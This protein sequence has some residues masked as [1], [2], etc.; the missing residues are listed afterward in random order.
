MPET[1][2]PRPVGAGERAPLPDVLRGLA[3]LGILIVNV[4]AFA[5]FREWTQTG[6]D[7]AVQVV[8][9]I[10]FNGRSISLFA[11]LFGWGAAGLLARHGPSRLLRRLLVLLAIGTLHY[12]F[13]WHG[14]IISTYSCWRW[15]CCS[16]PGSLRR[17]SSCWPGCWVDSG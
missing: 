13:V 10:V 6:L 16:R 3:L 1:G 17:P 12:V 4:Q 15:R 8:T 14:D 2:P 11:M 9:D 5:G 7:R